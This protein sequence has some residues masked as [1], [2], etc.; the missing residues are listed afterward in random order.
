MLSIKYSTKSDSNYNTVRYIHAQS[1]SPFK[2][3]EWYNVEK[4]CSEFIIRTMLKF[5]LKIS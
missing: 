5:I 2:P 1:L 4:Y 3:R